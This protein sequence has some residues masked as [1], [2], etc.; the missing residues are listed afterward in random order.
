MVYKALIMSGIREV[1]QQHF[2]F[3]VSTQKIKEKILGGRVLVFFFMGA[4]L[5]LIEFYLVCDLFL[6]T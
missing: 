1:K 4:L 2:S 6:V 5:R 3:L